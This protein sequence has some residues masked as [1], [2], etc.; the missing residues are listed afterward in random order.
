MDVFN[1]IYT[2]VSPS[3]TPWGKTGFHTIFYPTDL[4]SREDVHELE[5]RIHFP[6]TEAFREKETVFYQRI[7]GEYHLVIL[8]IRTLPDARDT[9]GRGG[10][11]LCHGFIFPPELWRSMPA[12]LTLFK[13]VKSEIFTSREEVLSS[14][15]VNKK[16]GDIRP[17][18]IS[19]NKLSGLATGL[20]HLSRE[21]EWK[22]VS[23]LNR[24]ANTTDQK[25]VILLKGE[26]RQI[27]AF[28]NNVAAYVPDDLKITLGWDPAFETGNLAF[29]PLKMV[30]FRYDRPMAG[31]NMIEINVESLAVQESPE[32]A[33]FFIPQTPC[34]KWLSHCRKEA[35]SKE[36][37]EKAYNLSLLLE[38]GASFTRDEVLAERSC[39]V[40]A[41][42][43]QIKEIFFKRRREILGESMTGYVENNL[44]CES[45]LDLLIENFPLEKTAAD[46]EEA[47][48]RHRLTPKKVKIQNMDSLAEAGTKRLR[49]VKRVW[50]K[51][52]VTPDDLNGL[53]R[54]E[55]EE[56]IRYLLTTEWTNKDWTTNLLKEDEQIFDKLLSYDDTAD[57]LKQAI[58]QVVRREKGFAKI[59][60]IMFGEVLGQHKGFAVLR[61]DISL[62][63]VLED[64]FKER[65]PDKQEM[66]KIISWAKNKKPPEGD[67]PY[68]KAFLYPKHGIPD[69]I[70]KNE[71][72]G[73]RLTACLIQYHKYGVRDFEK[74][75]FDGDKLAD[76]KKRLKDNTLIERFKRV[77]KRT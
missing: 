33:H 29:Y 15:L 40:S 64:I 11:F 34:E 2:K 12:P 60:K 42:Q 21:T 17:L 32:T 7:Q 72:V 54:K 27:S 31:G 61:Q 43:E 66:A 59:R 3:E 77:L 55:K 18:K 58:S 22:L 48:F 38:T 1:L 67:F 76:I 20:P 25:P 74:L 49:L 24:L 35:D 28:M 30:G 53:G 37:V 36:Q 14:S 8:H 16:T 70:L 62:T 19:R 63:D 46:V 71:V 39:F 45:M 68:I 75:G 69:D 73:E 44:I 50:E 9:F 41:N 65:L 57:T 52:S 10:V 4:M 51:E 23:L 5:K 56:F 6:G 13:L 26:A 47:I